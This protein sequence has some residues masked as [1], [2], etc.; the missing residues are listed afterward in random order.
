[1]YMHILEYIFFNFLLNI[2]NMTQLLKNQMNIK[3]FKFD[4]DVKYDILAS[5]K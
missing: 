1:M 4:T 5:M 3:E 2:W